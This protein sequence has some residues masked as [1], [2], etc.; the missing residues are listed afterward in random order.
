MYVWLVVGGCVSARGRFCVVHGW[1]FGHR[2]EDLGWG[3]IGDECLG[4]KT[5]ERWRESVGGGY[6][7]GEVS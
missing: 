7:D 5:L 4:V 1:G 3:G 2:A 6:L